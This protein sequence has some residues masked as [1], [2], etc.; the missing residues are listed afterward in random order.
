[1]P[2]FEKNFYKEHPNVQNMS[3]AEVEEYRKSKEMT[4][5]GRGVPRPVKNFTEMLF[6]G[7]VLCISCIDEGPG[8]QTESSTLNKFTWT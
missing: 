3:Q 7:I 1:M 2:K 4:I 6:P 5:S 8:Q